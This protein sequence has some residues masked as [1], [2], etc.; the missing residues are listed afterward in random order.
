MAGFCSPP[1]DTWPTPSSWLICWASLVSALSST[2]VSGS[3][4]E[5]TDKSMMGESAGLTLR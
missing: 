4:S 1:I 3:D 2:S 5:V